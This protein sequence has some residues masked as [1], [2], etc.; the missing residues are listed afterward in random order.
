MGP[1]EVLF[2]AITF[3]VAE[4]QRSLHSILHLLLRSNGKRFDL[5]EEVRGFLGH[6]IPLSTRLRCQRRN[7]ERQASEVARE[8]MAELGVSA[9]FLADVLES[10]R[11]VVVRGER[12][13]PGV[14]G[15]RPGW[16]FAHTCRLRE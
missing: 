15:I 13:S 3:L 2:G 7:R 8:Q 16:L 12:V 5:Q 6:V 4:T 11:V 10:V 1:A 14:D 9:L